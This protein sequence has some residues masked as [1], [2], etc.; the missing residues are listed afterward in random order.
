M[1]LDAA[2]AFGEITA[3]LRTKGTALYFFCLRFMCFRIT[4]KTESKISHAF[5]WK[6]IP[7]LEESAEWMAGGR[8]EGRNTRQP[9][10][11]ESAWSQGQA[12]WITPGCF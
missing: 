7:W 10:S 12:L 6:I 4:S 11:P 5:L 1:L 8:V 2:L 9:V 3:A